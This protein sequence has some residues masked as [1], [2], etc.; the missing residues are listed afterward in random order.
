MIYRLLRVTNERIGLNSWAESL[1]MYLGRRRIER[2]QQIEMLQN[3]AQL[4]ADRI[5]DI[6]AVTIM[7]TEYSDVLGSDCAE[8]QFCKEAKEGLEDGSIGIDGVMRNW[9]APE[10][11]MVVMAS[12]KTRNS[13]ALKDLIERTGKW[14][15]IKSGLIAEAR[16]PLV[17]IFLCALGTIGLATKGIPFLLD[18][19]P[20]KEWT[21]VIELYASLGEFLE[22][23]FYPFTILLLTIMVAYLYVMKY[24]NGEHRRTLDRYVPGYGFYQA[25]QASRFFSIMAILIS[26]KGAKMKLNPALEEFEMNPEL[27]SDY[28]SAHVSEMLDNTSEGDFNLDQLNTGLLP[29][30]MKI[31]LAVLGRTSNKL[32]VAETFDAIASNLAVSH[33]EVLLKKVQRFAN[34][35]RFAMILTGMG[36][37]AVVMEVA[38]LKLNGMAF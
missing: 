28:L 14:Q 4:K 6:E 7:L 24:Y 30:R 5:P 35:V 2:S 19:V 23:F 37:L 21:L 1:Y 29:A 15:K 13:S 3:Y 34:A 25:D 9:F 32:N 31:R 17:Y 16:K 18:G 38:L 36:M 12:K 8:S 22:R 27:M 20:R 11:A 33:G 10:L 26:P